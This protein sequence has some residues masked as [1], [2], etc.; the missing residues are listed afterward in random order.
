MNVN[1][2]ER[3]YTTLHNQHSVQLNEH[4][5]YTYTKMT[6]KR[7]IELGGGGLRTEL[8]YRTV[9]GFTNTYAI[10]VYHH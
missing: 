6:L 9:V 10:S 4:K 7:P 5:S 8:Y 1:E 3:L 2:H